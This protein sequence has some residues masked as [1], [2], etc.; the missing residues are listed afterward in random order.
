MKG[1]KYHTFSTKFEILF[2]VFISATGKNIAN[3]TGVPR[4]GHGCSFDHACNILNAIASR[5]AQCEHSISKR[6]GASSI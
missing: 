4:V 3:A 2:F 5:L 6:R 1:I